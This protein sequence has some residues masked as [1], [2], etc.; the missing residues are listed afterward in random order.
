MEIILP[1]AQDAWKATLHSIIEKGKEFKDNDHRDCKELLNVSVTITSPDVGIEEPIDTIKKIDKWVYPS[2]DELISIIFNEIE[3]PLYEYTYGSR[4]FGYQGTIDQINDYIIPLLKENPMS[5]RASI[6]TIDP[7]KDLNI[8]NKNAPGLISLHF[9][10]HD[11][12]VLL[13]A[14][15]RSNDFFIGWPA[16]IYQLAALQ[17]YVAEQLERRVGP[18]TTYSISAH[19]FMEYSEEIQKVLEK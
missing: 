11:E 13:T 17:Y 19:L 15:I 12:K 5:R 8:K 3:Q 4:I 16:N 9:K 2:K 14:V 6:V 7:R 18:L 1:T 10:I